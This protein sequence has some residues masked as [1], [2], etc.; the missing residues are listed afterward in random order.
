MPTTTWAATWRAEG[1]DPAQVTWPDI[2]YAEAYLESYRVFAQLRA[3]LSIQ[4]VDA[5]LGHAQGAK[6]PTP[7]QQKKIVDFEIA[8]SSSYA[9]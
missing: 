2:G 6:A 8:L 3:D 1:V 7:A 4:S 9:L 5:T